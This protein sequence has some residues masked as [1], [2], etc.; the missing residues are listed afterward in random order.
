[1]TSSPR[2]RRL[3]SAAALICTSLFAVTSCGSPAGGSTEPSGAAQDS[4][5]LVTTDPEGHE[6][7]VDHQ[8]QAALGFYTTDVDILATLGIPLSASQPIRGDSGYETFPA[9]FPQEA[10]QGITP[11]ANYPEFNYEKVLEAEP[12]FILNGLGYD[13][14]VHDKLATIAPTYTVNAFDGERW[15]THFE[16]TARDLGR[17]AQFN[18]WLGAYEQ[19]GKDALD[20]ITAAGNQDLVVAP[21]SYWGGEVQIGCYAWLECGAFETIGLQVA[22]KGKDEKSFT[23]E[24]LDQLKDIDAVWM[25]KGVGQVGEDEFNKTISELE[26]SPFWKDLPFVKNNRIYTYEMD[27]AYGSP[28]GALA[29]IEQVA[30]D[31]SGK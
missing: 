28:S 2:G 23:L 29:F 1:M 5:P 11:F 9:Y 20:G 17:E 4:T 7:S 25:T 21:I 18:E 14:E 27:M 15:N 31:L 30:S 3:L 12:D 26:K 22:Q 6:V 19:A 10:L 24:Q 13:P 16:R 8:P